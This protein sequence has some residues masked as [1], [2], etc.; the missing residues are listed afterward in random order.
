M[1]PALARLFWPIWIEFLLNTA[2]VSCCDR[3]REP[4]CDTYLVQRFAVRVIVV[5][6]VAKIIC[7]WRGGIVAV[8]ERVA[9]LMKGEEPVMM[10]NDNGKR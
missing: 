3:E 10:P 2:E 1:P 6:C 7:R 8:G 4:P 9:E 5:W